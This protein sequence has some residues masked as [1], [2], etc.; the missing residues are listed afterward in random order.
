MP[1]AGQTPG[2]AGTAIEK[3]S[4]NG[5]RGSAP[6]PSKL[7]WGLFLTDFAYASLLVVLTVWAFIRPPGVSLLLWALVS[8]PLLILWPGMRRRKH[9]AY[10]WLCFLI[11]A[12]FTKSVE[13]SMS[14][15][16][17]WS[18][19][20]VLTLSVF[21]FVSAMMTSRWL[22]QSAVVRSADTESV[23][24]TSSPTPTNTMERDKT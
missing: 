20:A 7:R 10:S 24:P 11:L 5:G 16:A 1:S 6:M 8:I 14:T 12:Y 3:S 13:G 17:S 18:D 4:M 23:S 2:S 15:V 21:I 9:R 19:Y 22:K